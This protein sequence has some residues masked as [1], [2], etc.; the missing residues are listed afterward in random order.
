MSQD[1]KFEHESMQDVHSIQKFLNSLNDGFEKGKISL[2]SDA[3]EVLLYPASLVQFRI[4]AKT[5]GDKSKLDIRISWKTSAADEKDDSLK[6][7]S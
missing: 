2:R 3:N 1:E 4:K 5:K 7:G 6:I